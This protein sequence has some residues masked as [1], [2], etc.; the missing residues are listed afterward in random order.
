MLEEALRVWR[1]ADY[2]MGIAHASSH[3]GR[4][5]A[6]S[7]DFEAAAELYEFAREHFRHGS[8]AEAD[9][10]DIDARIAEALLL[11]SRSAEVIDITTVLLEGIE[12]RG[13]AIQHPWLYRL[14]GY[15][16]AQLGRW[17]DARID[18]DRSTAI[19]R[20]RH[21]RYELAL[22]LDAIARITELSDGVV[23]QSARSEADELLRSLDVIYVPPVPL[24]ATS[25]A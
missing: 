1:A 12:S 3:L 14:R 21:A 6:R 11:Q 7:G 10:L 15:A 18:L 8:S 2:G 25:V 24:L 16:H 23:E 4:V 20:E 19:A 22:T 9:L 17:A 13:G 5:A